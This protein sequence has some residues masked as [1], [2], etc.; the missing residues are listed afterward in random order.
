VSA[1]VRRHPT[2]AGVFNYFG[3]DSCCGGDVTIAEAAENE[4]VDPVDLV[5]ALHSAIRYENAAR[6][7]G[8]CEHRCTI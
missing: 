1:I 8:S 4:F 6:L 2:T 3:I 5:A 7:A